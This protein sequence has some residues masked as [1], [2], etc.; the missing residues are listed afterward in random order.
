MIDGS[1]KNTVTVYHHEGDN[2]KKDIYKKVE[3][4]A[5]SQRD[6]LALLKINPEENSTT[7]TASP[8]A[9]NNSFQV[10]DPVFAIGNPLNLGRTVT[11]GKVSVA[12][13]DLGDYGF[14]IQH[15]APINPGNSGGALFNTRGEVIG[16]NTLK[17]SGG[18]DGLGFARPV[19]VIK[20]FLTSREAFAFDPATMNGA[21]NYLDPPTAD[22]Y[23]LKST[24]K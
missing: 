15:N 21:L 12:Y 19:S 1:Y 3:V 23:T 6:D 4:L 5:I 8:L 17:A 13:Q 22:I 2:L 14:F 7:L 9:L 11:D 10:G 20:Q 16:I 18:A 24:S